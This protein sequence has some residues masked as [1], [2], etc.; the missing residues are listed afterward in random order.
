MKITIYE[1]LGL[2]KDGKAPKKIKYR[3]KIWEYT[4]TIIGTG[5][6][7]Y[8]TFCEE[9][10]TLQ[11]QIYLEEC[12]NDYVEIIEEDKKIEKLLLDMNSKRKGEMTADYD[13]YIIDDIVKHNFD[14]IHKKINELIDEVNK[15]KEGK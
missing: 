5:Y 4:S 1:L 11:N 15:L 8:S 6:Q 2:I 9:W 7:Y 13:N 10:K 14:V 3:D 12:L